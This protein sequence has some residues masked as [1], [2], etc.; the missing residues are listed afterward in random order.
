MDNGQWTMDN[1]QWTINQHYANQSIIFK[2]QNYSQ[3]KLSPFTFHLSQMTT[4]TPYSQNY[5]PPVPT[6]FTKWKRVSKFWQFLRF[7]VINVRMLRMV[8]KH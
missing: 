4:R 7:L 3:T 1:G 8:R 2:N 5:Y 6:G